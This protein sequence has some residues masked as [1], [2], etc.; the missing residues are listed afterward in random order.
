AGWSGRSMAPKSSN[1]LD[2][3]ARA[4]R[5]EPMRPA[6]PV[7]AIEVVAILVAPS[8]LIST[9]GRTQ[10]RAAVPQKDLPILVSRN[11]PSPCPLPEGVGEERRRS[12][13]VCVAR[14]FHCLENRVEI[15]F[16]RD[17]RI[18]KFAM[19]RLAG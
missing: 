8:F 7:I 6:A 11:S 10:P 4:M 19:R 14:R 17:R 16:D 9:F 15:V 3:R 5:R 12:F 18:G 13:H 2:W 1:W